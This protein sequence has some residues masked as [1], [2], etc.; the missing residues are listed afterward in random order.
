MTRF[1]S[2]FL[3]VDAPTANKLRDKYWREHGTTLA[4]LMTH[5]DMPPE[6]F[7]HEVHDIDFDVLSPDPDL[8]DHIAKLP[9]RKIIYTNGSAPY[10]KKVLAARGLDGLFEEIYGVEHANWHPKPHVD[11][12]TTVF[13]R[14]AFNPLTAVMFEDDIRNLQV[15]HDLGMTTVHVAPTAAEHDHIHFHTDDLTA[16]LSQVRQLG[17]STAPVRPTYS[18]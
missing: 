17:F 16:F 3:G 7:M 10:A 8:A 15:P 14:A 11:A 6:V 9:G 5:H 12:F 13:G 18:P 4:G 2:E 1:V